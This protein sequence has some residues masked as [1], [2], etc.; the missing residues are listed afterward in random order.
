MSDEKNEK[1]ARIIAEW[2]K[3]KQKSKKH[4]DM[5]MEETSKPEETKKVMFQD[6]DMGDQIEY[7]AKKKAKQKG[8]GSD[9]IWDE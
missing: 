7:V 3:M 2:G 9:S 6:M 5:S 8:L 4:G 1:L